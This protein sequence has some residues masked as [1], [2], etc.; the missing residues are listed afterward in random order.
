YHP[1]TE[2]LLSAIPLI[3]PEAEQEYIRLEGELPSPV[4]VPT[5]CPF[6]TRCPHF[7]GEICVNEEPPWR[8]TGAGK[9]YFC[10]IPEDELRALQGRAFSQKRSG[11]DGS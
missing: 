3:E 5:G 11:G 2:S 7:L 9:R 1:Y 10:H 8:A 6:H 4:D